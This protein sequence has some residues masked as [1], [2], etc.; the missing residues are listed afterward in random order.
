MIIIVI[1][2]YMLQQEKIEIREF[3]KTLA[4]RSSFLDP[5]NPSSP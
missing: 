5:E 1:L 4:S 3:M 2:E